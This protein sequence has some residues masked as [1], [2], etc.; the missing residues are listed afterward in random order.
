VFWKLLPVLIS[1]I[2]IVVSALLAHFRAP[3]QVQRSLPD[4]IKALIKWVVSMV[5]RAEQVTGAAGVKLS[6]AGNPEA[7]PT[8]DAVNEQLENVALA[9]VR[10]ASRDSVVTAQFGDPAAIATGVAAT[11]DDALRKEIKAAVAS[12]NATRTATIER[13]VTL[14]VPA[15]IAEATAR[16]PSPASAEPAAAGWATDEALQTLLSHWPTVAPSVKRGKGDQ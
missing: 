16:A 8:I 9:E 10:S 5:T 4:A 3:D 2:G 13:A 12:S 6:A 1:G 15:S 7:R 14:G 11:G